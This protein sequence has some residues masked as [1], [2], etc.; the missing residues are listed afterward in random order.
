MQKKNILLIVSVTYC[1]GNKKR[2]RKKKR[3]AP[4]T[5]NVTL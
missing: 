4:G 2:R 5:Y 3:R 1:E